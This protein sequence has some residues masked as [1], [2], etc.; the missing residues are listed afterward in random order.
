MASGTMALMSRLLERMREDVATLQEIALDVERDAEARS[1]EARAT[2]DAAEI[3]RAID[4]AIRAGK[5]LSEDL[6]THNERASIDS[7]VAALLA[8]SAVHSRARS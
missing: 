8:L 2:T 3:E 4:L 5:R 6:N 7:T 1:S